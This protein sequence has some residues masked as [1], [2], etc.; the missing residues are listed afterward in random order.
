MVVRAADAGSVAL[1]AR[2]LSQG[3][4]AIIPCDTMYGI[5]GTAPD[6]EKRIRVIKGRGET[7]PVL[8]LIAHASW[9]ARI[10]DLALPP[11]LAKYW[12]GPLTIIFPARDGGTV[13]LRLPDSPFLVKLMDS[14]GRPLYSTSVNRTGKEPMFDIELMKREFETQVDIIFDAGS[15]PPGPASTLVDVT[16]HPYRVLRSGV[17]RIPPENLD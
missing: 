12:P 1:L 8:Q 3:G 10:S 13:A 16:T 4:V 7:K 5:V 15:V 11:R 6:T 14:V 17:V 9:V 2:A